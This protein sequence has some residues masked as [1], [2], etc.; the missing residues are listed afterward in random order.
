[1]Y[2]YFIYN[3]IAKEHYYDKIIDHKILEILDTG[4]S[5]WHL[6]PPDHR[7]PRP[8]TTFPEDQSH[9]PTTASFSLIQTKATA[10]LLPSI[11]N[12]PDN[13]VCVTCYAS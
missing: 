13:C 5:T 11:F 9:Q 4:A 2:V 7:R 6:H 3:S 10:R 1:M 8:D 12:L